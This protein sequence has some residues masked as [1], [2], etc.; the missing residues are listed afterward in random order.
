M[1]A[2]SR[3]DLDDAAEKLE[4]A[5]ASSPTLAEAHTGLGLV[6][7]TQGEKDAAIVAYQQALQLQPDN[8]LAAGGLAR[9][10]GASSGTDLPANHPGAASGE[11]SE[12]GDSP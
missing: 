5:I 11:D 4:A 2:Y 8:F 6:R 1:A 12:Q 9:L 3:G 7:E 10:T